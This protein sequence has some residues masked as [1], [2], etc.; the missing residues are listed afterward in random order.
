MNWLI[1]TLVSSIGRKVLMALTGIFLI[2]FL[3]VHLAGNLQLFKDD[4]GEAFNLYSYFM[5]HQPVIKTV[6]YLLYTSILLHVFISGYITLLNMRARPVGYAVNGSSANS[7]WSSRNMGILGSIIFIFLAIH[8]QNFWYKMH[9]KMEPTVF[10]KGVQYKDLYTEVVYAF[11]NPWISALYV[12]GMIGLAYHLLHGFQS[13]FQTLGIE[14][15][16]Y[17][18]VLKAL[19]MIFSILVPALFAVMP[20]YFYFR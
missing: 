10:Y 17:T 12:V 9:W 16:K 8:L 5:T 18:P 20:L 4:G 13:S 3:L 11:Q 19:G 2:I 14:H 6:S 7:T 1:N 15:K